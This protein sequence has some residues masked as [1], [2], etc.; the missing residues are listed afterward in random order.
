[1]VC[2]SKSRTLADATNSITV[3][4]VKLSKSIMA[5]HVKVLGEFKVTKCIRFFE[6]KTCSLVCVTLCNTLQS[7]ATHYNTSA[8]RYN[9]LQHTETHYNT[10]QHTATHCNTLQHTATH[11]NTLQHAAGITHADEKNIIIFCL[12]VVLE[13][14]C[15][16]VSVRVCACV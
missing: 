11:C 4:N 16:Y 6:L 3:C 9:T 1:M 7:C 14:L 15:V 2:M 13:S 8:A 10:L 12:S 5:C